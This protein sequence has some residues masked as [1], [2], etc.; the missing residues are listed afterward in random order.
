MYVFEKRDIV[1]IQYFR[2][3]NVAKYFS[4]K[5]RHKAVRTSLFIPFPSHSKILSSSLGCTQI[6]FNLKSFNY[7]NKSKVKRNCN[8]E[9]CNR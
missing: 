1:F 2:K 8:K 3:I 4:E 5:G 6:L 7:G 9:K